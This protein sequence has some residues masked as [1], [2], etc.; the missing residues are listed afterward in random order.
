[1]RRANRG[2]TLVLAALTALV[3]CVALLATV[4]VGAAV[5]ARVQAQD[6]AD[7]AAYSLATLEARA[8]NFYAVANRTQASHYASAM[9]LQSLVS[10]AYSSE[11]ILTDVYGVMRTLDPCAQEPRGLWAVTCPALKR[12]P[13]VGPALTF[14]DGALALLEGLVAAWQATLAASGLDEQ[15]GAEAIPTLR[16]LNSALAHV[17]TA[18]MQATLSQVRAGAAEIL[19]KNGAGLVEPDLETSALA[20]CLFDRAHVREANGSPLDPN[21][22]AGTPL[23]PRARAEDDRTA[24]AKRVMAQVANATRASCDEARP[25]CPAEFATRRSSVA[26]PRWLDPIRGLLEAAPRWGT[27]RLLTW[28]LGRGVDDSEGGNYLREPVDTPGAGMAMLAQGDVLGADDAYSLHLG[29][30]QLAGIPNPLACAVT[31]AP[32]DCWGDPR[33]GLRRDRPYRFLLE[34]SVWATG[35][36]EPGVDRGGVHWRIAQVSGPRV[37]GWRRPTAPGALGALGLNE[38]RKL[39]AGM[40]VSIFVANVQPLMDGNHRWPGLAP[41]MHFE[42]GQYAAA[43]DGAGTRNGR[44]DLARAA[45]RFAE[46][47][48]PASWVRLQRRRQKGP[49]RLNPAHRLGVHGQ[50]L[51]FGG[52]EGSVIARA[53]AYYHRPGSWAEP[54]NF[55]NPYWRARLASVWQGRAENPEVQALLEGL[56]EPLRE[57]PQKVLVH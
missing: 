10:F 16:T 56:P 17:S 20:A 46:F 8:F 4:H 5:H 25:D 30:A 18:V 29:P 53:Q 21:R 36:D 54:P 32:S 6:T 28:G 3:V 35:D 1:M 37:R 2:Q 52:E 55:F 23:L 22:H 50:R 12:V 34:T 47:N 19:L 41:F 45:A 49:W 9:L 48:Q 26:L 51:E 38:V 40:P 57:H 44:P 33:Y 11:A 14:L 7:A 24:R 27:S 39:I 15:L 13:V 42:P 43:C 31:D